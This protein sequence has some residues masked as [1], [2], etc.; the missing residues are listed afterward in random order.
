MDDRY[1]TPAVL[2]TA[3]QRGLVESYFLKLN[4]PAG[5]WALWLK[6]TFLRRPR[7]PG[8]QAHC[9]AIFF[10]R[11]NRTGTP[12]SGHRE[13]FPVGKWSI[14]EEAGVL[15]L[16]ENRLSPGACTG[17]L[18]N[19][20]LA[21]DLR[22]SSGPPAI[23]AV[24]RVTLSPLVPTTKLT[25]PHP[26][27]DASG[28]VSVAGETFTFSHFPLSVGHNWG[29]RHTPGYVWGQA[30]SLDPQL[31]FF[32]EGFSVPVGP[33]YLT[34][35]T[36]AFDGK[37][38]TFSNPLYIPRTT[39]HIESRR[40]EFSLT[41][42]A[43]ELQGQFTLPPTLTAALRYIQPSG[44][45]HSC[46]NSMVADAHFTLLNRK[47][48]QR[49]SIPIPSTSALEFLLPTLDHPFPFIT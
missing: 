34:M 7:T 6:Y 30:R 17:T 39:T 45:I 47:S 18:N 38:H 2:Q 15:E 46:I 40:W 1:W 10:D 49:T 32:F 3:Y 20:R 5:R 43:W 4:E 25:T 44:S 41:N 29:Y 27:S 33:R 14:Q 8:A 36:M 26:Q 35:G 12:L 48:G 19:G 23:S 9:W 16:G 21:W 37:T 28:T 24:P 31:P 22:F 13:D 11:E 42:H